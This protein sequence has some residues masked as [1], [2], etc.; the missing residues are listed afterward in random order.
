MARIR[1]LK[2]QFFKHPDLA[3]LPPCVRLFFAGLW[4]QADREGRLKDRPK[5][6]KVEIAPYDDLDADAALGDLAR[7]GFIVRYE[8]A[9]ERFISIPHFL[10]HQKPHHKEAASE[11]PP[12]PQ[13]NTPSPSPAPTQP[14][15]NQGNHDRD[16][17][18]QGTSEPPSNPLGSGS[19]VLGSGSLGSGSLEPGDPPVAPRNAGGRSPKPLRLRKRNRGPTT[20]AEDVRAEQD[21][22]R[23]ERSKLLH[24]QLRRGTDMDREA[25][26]EWVQQRC[27]ASPEEAA[28]VVAIVEN[29]LGLQTNGVQA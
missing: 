8:S 12:P 10:K 11:I 27:H 24:E 19:L 23:N 20:L 4:C 13:G 26:L 15:L 22:I 25:Q 2:P 29:A 16:E 3:E 21:R 9:G 5:F 18:G 17:S 6:L 7:A 28:D 14:G 1:F